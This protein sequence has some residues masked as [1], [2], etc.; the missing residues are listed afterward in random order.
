MAMKV[1]VVII[2]DDADLRE[3]ITY[4]LEE[5]GYRVTAL[6]AMETLEALIDLK[7]DCFILDE[8]LPVISG[9]IICILLKSKAET[10]QI[11]VILISGHDQLEGV[12]NLCKAEAFVKKPFPDIQQLTDLIREAVSKSTGVPTLKQK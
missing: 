3:T 9:H 5:S 6:G 7:A 12:A 2:E 11:P 4:L 8:Q 1:H 10:S